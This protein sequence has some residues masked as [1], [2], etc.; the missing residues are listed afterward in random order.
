M[1]FITILALF[2]IIVSVFNHAAAASE[3]IDYNTIKERCNTLFEHL[4]SH[5]QED[6]ETAKLLYRWQKYIEGKKQYSNEAIIAA[7]MNYQINY[8][9]SLSELSGC[10]DEMTA[11]EKQNSSVKWLK[12]IKEKH[13][14]EYLRDNR[15][16]IVAV[17]SAAHS[18]NSENM[19]GMK[20]KS[21]FANEKLFFHV[22]HPYLTEFLSFYE[23]LDENGKAKLKSRREFVS[24]LLRDMERGY[25]GVIYDGF[26]TL[27]PHMDD[28]RAKRENQELYSLLMKQPELKR[29]F[30]IDPVFDYLI[31]ITEK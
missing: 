31:D 19:C 4:N 17:I 3:I 20:W 15:R 30:D 7:I 14:E 28:F 16:S 23:Q 18:M 22:C 29:P 6:K 27:R 5:K 12:D 2:G 10:I 9:N 26:S 21:A 1:R 8:W 25:V 24:I 13:G 11:Q